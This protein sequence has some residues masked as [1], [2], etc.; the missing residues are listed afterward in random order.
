MGEENITKNDPLDLVN[1]LE[2]WCSEENKEYPSH[3]WRLRSLNNTPHCTGTKSYARIT[4][5]DL[6]E[7]IYHIHNLNERLDELIPTDP[8][9]ST[10]VTHGMVRWTP[11]DAYAQVN[12]NKPE[13]TGSAEHVVNTPGEDLRDDLN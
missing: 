6:C 3:M 1:L 11:N 13:Y 10:S 7:P 4:H 8:A 5:E 12:G 9:A 2:K